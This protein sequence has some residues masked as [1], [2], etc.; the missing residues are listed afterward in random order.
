M[1]L[2]SD[3]ESA[4]VNKGRYQ[5]LVGKFIYLSHIRQVIAFLVSLVSR[6]INNP[7]EEHMTAIQRI[8]GYL[9]LIPG[10]GLSFRKNTTKE[11]IVHPDA[12]WVDSIIDRRSTSG[13]C[14]TV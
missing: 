2:G 11:V 12:D 9:K 3:R 13:Y 1:K 7:V 5:W 6:F 10:K 14:T 8:L 4:P